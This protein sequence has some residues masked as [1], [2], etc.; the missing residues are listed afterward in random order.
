MTGP[1]DLCQKDLPAT[2]MDNG[3]DFLFAVKLTTFNPNAIAPFTNRA[4]IRPLLIL[5]A[6][7]LVTPFNSPLA[8]P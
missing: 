7:Y 4:S 6:P 2:E 5:V 8:Q 3:P 1:S